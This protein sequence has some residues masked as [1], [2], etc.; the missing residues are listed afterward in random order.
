M[1]TD[2]LIIGGGIAGLTLASALVKTPLNVILIDQHQAWPSFSKEHPDLR[3]SAIT[4][5]SQCVL[6]RLGAWK[7]ICD[8]RVSPYYE[9]HVWDAAGDGFIH[10]D[11]ADIGEPD[12][13]HI[14]ENTVIQNALLK[15]LE[16]A[17]NIH[18]Y[19]DCSPESFSIIEDLAQ[20][21]TADG[22]HFEAQLI[23]GADGAHSWLRQQS[24]IE[25]S[26]RSYDQTAIIATIKTEKPHQSTA[27]QRFTPEGIL[28]F[29]PLEN[30]HHSSIV[31]STQSENAKRL[32][33][34]SKNSFAKALCEAFDHHLG[35]IDCISEIAGF[36]L[37]ARH[38]KEYVLPH[39]AFIG[40]AAHIIHPL[41]GQG[42]NLG[43]LDAAALAQ[44]L[45][46]AHQKKRNIAS[47]QTLNRYARWRYGHNGAMLAAMS[48]FKHVFGN[49]TSFVK[50]WR[51][52]GL[53][54]VNNCQI[55]KNK[56][57]R[58]AMGL[59][60]DLPAIAKSV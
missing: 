42:I 59:E 11:A 31:W 48:G 53:S 46:A 33:A 54:W 6:S 41:A 52:R 39:I 60:G 13:G 20:L 58:I 30:P 50:Q 36:P 21:T 44:T 55:V 1:R 22:R 47:L 12:L 37:F 40:D 32:L 45:E 25:Q 49:N 38:N 19:N 34:L 17:D 14:I 9:M 26:Q 10:F 43:I 27:W 57:M 18:L 4:R 16:G 2:V 23:V 29:L 24:S 51:N 28:A 7:T 35:E 56:I 8:F 3:V 15:T 5:A